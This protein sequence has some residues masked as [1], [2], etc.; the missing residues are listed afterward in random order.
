MGK[1]TGGLGRPDPGQ[2]AVGGCYAKL[3]LGRV[4]GCQRGI[5]FGRLVDV[6]KAHEG[7]LLRNTV[8]KELHGVHDLYGGPVITAY[9]DVG[10]PFHGLKL[11]DKI[12][13][14][15]VL[16]IGFIEQGVGLVK[17]KPQLIE[18]FA[19]GVKTLLESASHVIGVY[20]R[21]S[22]NSDRNTAPT[23]TTA[24]KNFS[25]WSKTETFIPVSEGRKRKIFTM[26][27]SIGIRWKL[28]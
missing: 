25:C 28:Y 7:N 6:I 27:I 8:S 1:D 3:F 12:G 20:G 18:G 19:E 16:V 10:K 4:Y 14:I 9:I 2:Q 22:M 21:G 5:A 23:V 13:K 11:I 24:E 17:G 26:A 15:H